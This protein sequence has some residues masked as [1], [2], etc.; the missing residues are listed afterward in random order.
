[1]PMK[2]P[3]HP[4][5]SVLH[6]CLE[7]LGLSV[8]DAARKLGVSRKHLSSLINGRAGISAE[9][10]IRLDKAFG[11]GASAWYQM[12]AAYELAQALRRADSIEVERIAAGATGG[13]LQRTTG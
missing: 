12:Q 13:N 9:M 5:L 7:P 10:A 6:D 3:P 8:A 2:A 1:M 4:G 11:G